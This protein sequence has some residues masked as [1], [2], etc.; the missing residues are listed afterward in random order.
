MH[1]LWLETQGGRLLHLLSLYLQR[2]TL[3]V[4]AE[5]VQTVKERVTSQ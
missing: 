2:V 3:S 5:V 4:R 1:C